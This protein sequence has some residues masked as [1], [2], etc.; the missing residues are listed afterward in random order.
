V[1]FLNL[2]GDAAPAFGTVK[3]P[4]EGFWLRHILLWGIPPAGIDDGLHIIKKLFGDDRLML[5]F[6]HLTP[7]TEMPVKHWVCKQL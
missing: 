5:A 6:I 4:H 3:K 2:G 7:V 1:T